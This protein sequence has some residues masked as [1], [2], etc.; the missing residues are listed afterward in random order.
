MQSK[1]MM[2]SVSIHHNETKDNRIKLNQAV[3]LPKVTHGSCSTPAE[4]AQNG[5]ASQRHK[6]KP[7]RN[8]KRR[9]QRIRK[10]IMNEKDK[11]SKQL[12]TFIGW[13]YLYRNQTRM[14]KTTEENRNRGKRHTGIMQQI[15]ANQIRI[16]STGK[17]WPTQL[18]IGR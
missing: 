3:D 15:F 14:R 5:H 8:L 6:Y 11:R 13:A 1:H 17:P 18:G 12:S 7:Y 2:E 9:K 4:I 16:R 10:Q